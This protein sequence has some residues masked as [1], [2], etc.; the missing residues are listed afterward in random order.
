M[1]I[2]LEFYKLEISNLHVY[3]TL[4]IVRFYMQLL[5]CCVKF[6]QI[7]ILMFNFSF[8]MVKKCITIKTFN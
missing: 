5:L 8:I 4:T 3:F 2:E 1:K 6:I 7:M